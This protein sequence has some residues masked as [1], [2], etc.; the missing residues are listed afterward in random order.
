MA[1]PGQATCDRIGPR[2]FLA[3]DVRAVPGTVGASLASAACAVNRILTDVLMRPGLAF[4]ES[5][6]QPVTELAE[7]G[8]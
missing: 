2:L 4:L 7:V 6:W 3:G 8:E 5:G 1:E